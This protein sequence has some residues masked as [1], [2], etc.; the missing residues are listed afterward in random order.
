MSAPTQISDDFE[1]RMSNIVDQKIRTY[2]HPPANAGSVRLKL[3]YNRRSTV[4][5][6][7]EAALQKFNWSTY[8]GSY[9]RSVGGTIRLSLIQLPRYALKVTLDFVVSSDANHEL[10]LGSCGCRALL[11]TWTAAARDAG[12]VQ[13]C[14]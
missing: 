12:F 2:L 14:C 4:N 7:S 1:E 13:G 3:T 10:L 11:E 5:F 6:V 8:R 9:S